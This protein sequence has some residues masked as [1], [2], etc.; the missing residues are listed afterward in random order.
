MSKIMHASIPS[1]DPAKAAR[2][3]AEILEGEAL[4]FPPAGAN[5][6][7]VF[8]G[9]GSIDLEVMPRGR[10]I[11]LREGEA[12]GVFDT[13][14]DPQRGSECHLALCVDRPE[15]E[16]IDIA[17]RAG[18]EAR[19]CERGRGLFG[20]AE[21][22]IDNTFMIEVLDPVQAARYRSSVSASKWKQH[23]QRMQPGPG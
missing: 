19:H 23:L 18:C 1:D 3:L 17:R 22:W 10:L 8:A 6:W 21:V 4:P 20:L 5:A 15:A 12:E 13:T 2:M 9:D 7:K 16:V 14:A 11:L